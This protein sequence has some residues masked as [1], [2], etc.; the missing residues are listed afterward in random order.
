M[1]KEKG[2]R[3][4]EKVPCIVCKYIDNMGLES[5][6]ELPQFQKNNYNEESRKEALNDIKADLIRSLSR[7]VDCTRLSFKE[8]APTTKEELITC[9]F[10]STIRD[11]NHVFELLE[12]YQDLLFTI[13]EANKSKNKEDL[14]NSIYE[15]VFTIIHLEEVTPY[16]NIRKLRNK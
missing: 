6:L 15:A 11:Y 10:L 16:A 3:E 5:L 12:L 9:G 13:I 1:E 14:K 7:S 4:C 2:H 8:I